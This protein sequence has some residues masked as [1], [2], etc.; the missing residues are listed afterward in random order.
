M[1]KAKD[2]VE[3][4]AN[5][6]DISREFL[7]LLPWQQES[8][9]QVSRRGR[10]N[11]SHALVLTG[12]AGTGKRRFADHLSAWLLCEQPQ[13]S[14][15]CGH[16]ESCTWLKAGNHPNLLRVSREIDA[17]G[18][19]SRQIKIDQI[20]ELIPLVQQTGHG[21][22]IVILE[23][24]EA[25]NTAAANALLKTLEEPAP[26]VLL[27]LIADQY[28]QLPATIRSRVQQIALGRIDQTLAQQFIQ[29]EANVSASEAQLLLGL[30]GGAPLAAIA[31]AGQDSFRLRAPWL[32]TWL[33]ILTQKRTPLD[34][35]A[36]WLKQLSLNDW[37]GLVLQLVRDGIA[38]H[39][40]Q[41]VIQSDLNPDQLQEL[42][43]RVPLTAM[44]YY[45]QSVQKRIQE[46]HQNINGQLV[47]EELMTK[48]AAPEQWTFPA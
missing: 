18:K 44:F 28:L 32:L 34:A 48:L 38:L 39:L 15:A 1:A 30:T 19:Q 6:P 10:D 36:Y 25:L 12:P 43:R 40:D 31:L 24:A 17:K 9:Q 16:C 33:A 5:T 21:W 11:L 3:V 47:M 37:L 29:T 46:Q 2:S 41:T 42:I 45:Q 22:R 14:G 35:A 4:V 20:R 27:L 26:H 13:S 8:W 23:P 7:P